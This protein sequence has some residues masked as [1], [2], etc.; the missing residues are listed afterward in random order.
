MTLK[1][2]AGTPVAHLRQTAVRLLQKE[3]R[4]VLRHTS[5]APLRVLHLEQQ[6]S[7]PNLNE[8]SFVV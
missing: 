2:H 3:L 6:F 7:L 8:L 1:A 5:L 4:F